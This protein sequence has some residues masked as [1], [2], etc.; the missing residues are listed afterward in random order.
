MRRVL[1]ALLV[2]LLLCPDLPARDVHQW[3]NVQ[4]LKR[5]TPVQVVLWNGTD[6]YGRI[7]SVSANGIEVSVPDSVT[8][9]SNWIQAVHRPSVREVVRRSGQMYLP[10]P[11][12][13]MI[14]GAVAGAAGGVASGAIS[15]ARHGYQGRWLFGGLI[16]SFGGAMLGVMSAAVVAIVQLPAAIAHRQRVIFEA[17]TAPTEANH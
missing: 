15:D 3:R 12:R 8:A 16:G 14:A 2:A 10:D 5:G 1:T 11:H 4:K 9:K 6:V 13:W 17:Q 7:H